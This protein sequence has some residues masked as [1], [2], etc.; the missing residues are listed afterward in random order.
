VCVYCR[1]SLVS[2]KWPEAQSCSFLQP[3][4]LLM[5]L[6]KCYLVTAKWHNSPSC[7]LNCQLS[8]QVLLGQ[9]KGLTDLLKQFATVHARYTA[10][11]NTL[12]KQGTFHNQTILR[13][14]SSWTCHPP[15]SNL[16]PDTLLLHTLQDAPLLLLVAE[17]A[18]TH[19]P[20]RCCRHTRHPP[21]YYLPS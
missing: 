14:T 1:P 19:Q 17:C 20:A 3:A 9:S 13:G 5:S 11:L 6:S 4:L 10:R 12:N 2:V 15:T 7:P 8:H 21:T 18:A 16:T